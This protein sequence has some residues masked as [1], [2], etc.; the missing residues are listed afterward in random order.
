MANPNVLAVVI[1]VLMAGYKRATRLSEGSP[2]L[3][4]RM[5]LLS[6]KLHYEN[7]TVQKVLTARIGPKRLADYHDCKNDAIETAFQ[8][9]GVQLEPHEAE[10]VRIMA[11]RINALAARIRGDSYYGALS[12]DTVWLLSL[13]GASPN[14]LDLIVGTTAE[15]NDLVRRYERLYGYTLPQ[16]DVKVLLMTEDNFQFRV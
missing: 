10:L 14:S 12:A 5:H 11:G 8:E 2:V 6:A 4:D 3:L 16:E 13:I 15:P 9:R 1:C 7:E